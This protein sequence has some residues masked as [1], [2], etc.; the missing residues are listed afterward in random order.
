M[1]SSAVPLP[2]ACGIQGAAV[3]SCCP[4]GP[5]SPGPCDGH[6][7]PVLAGGRVSV[8]LQGVGKQHSA[9]GLYTS[10]LFR[11]YE[12]GWLWRLY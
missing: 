10:K 1:V 8:I 12:F 6:S 9:C 11:V 7:R 5:E 3:T 4:R 2:R